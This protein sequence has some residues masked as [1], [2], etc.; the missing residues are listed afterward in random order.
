MNDKSKNKYLIEC[1]NKNSQINELMALKKNVCLNQS[2]SDVGIFDSGNIICS[3]LDG[4]FSIFDSNFERIQYKKIEKEEDQII[5]IAIKAQNILY[6]GFKSG[7]VEIWNVKNPAN[8]KFE[9]FKRRNCHNSFIYQILLFRYY[10][11]TCSEDKTI[12]KWNIRKFDDDC[13]YEINEEKEGLL[14]EIYSIIYNE[15]F[16]ILVSSG[17]EGTF[18]FHEYSDNKFQKIIT[19][20]KIISDMKI[21]FKN[22][23]QLFDEND[24]LIKFIIGNEKI[25]IFSISKELKININYTIELNYK[26]LSI[27]V[28]KMKEKIIFLTSEI[29]Y[30]DDENHTIKFYQKSG[31]NYLKYKERESHK[32]EIIGIILYPNIINTFIS[33]SLDNYLKLWNLTIE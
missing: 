27:C 3:T 33:F 29:R 4:S 6:F 28:I 30:N 19:Y 22:S 31:D 20:D 2:I 5:S 21:N 10:F 15:N 25:I 7:D 23:L 17:S 12:K 11:F 1:L 13:L 32:K 26:C 8:F 9:M 14:G 24:Q 16:K 18:I